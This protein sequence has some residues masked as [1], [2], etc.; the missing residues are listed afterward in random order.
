MTAIGLDRHTREPAGLGRTMTASSILRVTG[1]EIEGTYNM[2]TG[3]TAID[4]IAITI[5]IAITTIIGITT[6][7]TTTTT[8]I[9]DHV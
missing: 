7:T 6:K 2:I 9:T 3:G 1:T 8:I 4:A 5:T